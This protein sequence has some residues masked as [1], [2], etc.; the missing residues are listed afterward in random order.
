M[1]TNLVEA[2]GVESQAEVEKANGDSIQHAKQDDCLGVYGLV[3]EEV[4][5]QR[6]VEGA[7]CH[8]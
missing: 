1:E 7:V 4:Q 5:A 3:F 6:R 8:H 2:N